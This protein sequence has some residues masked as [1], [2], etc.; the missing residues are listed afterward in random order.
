MAETVKVDIP[1]KLTRATA[2][3]R[4]ESGFG[5]LRQDM[6]GG[7]VKFDDV[8]T[9]DHLDFT[10][11]VMGQSVTGRL[12]VLD[13]NVHVEIDLPGFLAA[14]ANKLRGQIQKEGALLL[15]KK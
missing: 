9:D 4:I 10:A 12:D 7:M 8:W 15:E 2:R 11:K 6:L 3:A 5:R 13:D 14:I 1:H